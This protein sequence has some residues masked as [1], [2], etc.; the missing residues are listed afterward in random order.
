VG[1]RES[2]VACEGKKID[3]G[4]LFG[5]A[6]GLREFKE[7]NADL[8]EVEID[9]AAGPKIPKSYDG[10]SHGMLDVLVRK[11]EEK[12]IP[13]VLCEF[14]DIHS[15][16]DMPQKRKG[17]NRSSVRQCL[18][19]L[20]YARRGMFPSDPIDL[21]DRDRYER[22]STVL[23]RQRTPSILALHYPCARPVQRSKPHR[24]LRRFCRLHGQSRLTSAC[25]RGFIGAFISI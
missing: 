2:R 11:E 25:N 20:S 14:K 3:V 18:D 22:V 10:V 21:G 24:G 17:N 9:H 4:G 12:P 7:S 19:Y 8:V 15:D 13:Q 23:V 16:R 5:A 6:K 1:R